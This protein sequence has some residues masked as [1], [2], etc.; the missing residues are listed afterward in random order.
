MEQENTF[1]E[2]KKIALRE[3]MDEARQNRDRDLYFK[4]R[5]KY[6][7]LFPKVDGGNN[8]TDTSSE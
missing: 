6:R 4:L 1:K 2:V 5:K 7:I 8:D 3:L